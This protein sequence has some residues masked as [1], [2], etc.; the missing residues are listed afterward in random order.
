LGRSGS[1]PGCSA[2]GS[3]AESL[4]PNPDAG[5]CEAARLRDED[6]STLDTWRVPTPPYVPGRA[7]LRPASLVGGSRRSRRRQA[8][9]D[10]HRACAHT[11]HA[12]AQPEV[13]FSSGYGADR[14]RHP[15][16]SLHLRNTVALP[17]RAV[18]ARTRRRAG[19][20]T[21]HKV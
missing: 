18:L 20:V 4:P 11:R 12:R 19:P 2:V 8:R 1:T 6:L 16:C 10:T 15:A 9:F 3:T 5:R 7:A 14:P 13:Q 17:R 21:G